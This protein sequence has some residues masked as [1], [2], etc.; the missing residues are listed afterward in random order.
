M[1]IGRSI[2]STLVFFD[3][4][5]V[6][7]EERRLLLCHLDGIGLRSH[8]DCPVGDKAPTR[9]MATV[10]LAPAGAVYL[11]IEVVKDEREAAPSRLLAGFGP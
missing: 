4:L 10:V 3:E 2:E 11:S 1:R 7:F 5:G 9:E 6:L 8:A